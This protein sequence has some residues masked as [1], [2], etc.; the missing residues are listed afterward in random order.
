MANYFF[1]CLILVPRFDDIS[2]KFGNI[3]VHRRLWDTSTFDLATLETKHVLHLPYQLMDVFLRACHIEIE[4]NGHSQRD[5]AFNEMQLIR[6]LLYLRGVSPFMIPFAT[7]HSINDYSGIN[8][9]DSDSLRD[10]LPEALKKGL[11]SESG[12]LEAWYC[13]RTWTLVRDASVIDVNPESFASVTS[14]LTSWRNI[15]REYPTVNIVRRLFNFAPMIP[16]DGASILQIWQGIESLFPSVQTE[17][18]FRL[19]LLI[20]QLCSPIQQRT[21]TYKE[22]KRLYITR[23]KITHGALAKISDGA[24]ATHWAMLRLCLRAILVRGKLPGEE[25]LMSELMPE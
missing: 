1:P 25:E 16:D 21:A 13:D 6:T 12:T 24:W 5:A 8:S 2:L 23:S 14:Q 3:I 20:S 22:A 11:T 18:T 17:V 9:R 19:A 4:I 10:K 7:T 15:E